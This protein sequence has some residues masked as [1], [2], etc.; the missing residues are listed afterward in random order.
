MDRQAYWPKTW[1]H[2]LFD[3]QVADTDNDGATNRDRNR[4]ARSAVGPVRHADGG[5][6]DD[7]IKSGYLS[8]RTLSILRVEMMRPITLT[9]PWSVLKPQTPDK[10]DYQV[11]DT[12]AGQHTS[13]RQGDVFRQR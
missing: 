10:G 13:H 2:R 4:R 3:R 12:C 6:A 9:R 11:E 5:D 1:V 8:T 7:V